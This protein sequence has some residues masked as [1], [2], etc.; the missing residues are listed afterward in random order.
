M[1]A[2]KSTAR[3]LLILLLMLTSVSLIQ[4]QDDEPVIGPPVV[5]YISSPSRSFTVTDQSL[6]VIGTVIV[7]PEVVAY[8]KV[9]I[10]GTAR[11]SF[12]ARD[13]MDRTLAFD[14]LTIGDI[15][16]DT[17]VEGELARLPHWPGISTGNWLL[18]LV[19]VG[20]DS[21][22]VVPEF[23]V[24]FRVQVP[25]TD[26]VY[27]NIT[28]PAP[29]QIL[30][31]GSEILGTILMDQWVTEYRLELIGGD[32]TSWT[33]VHSELSN[34]GNPTR[35]TDGVLGHLPALDTLAPGQYRLRVV[36]IGWNGQ[37]RQEPREIDFAVGTNR[38]TNLSSIRLTQPRVSGDR[39][40]ITT[41]TPLIGTVIVPEG[42][43]YYKVEIKDDIRSGSEQAVRFYEWT[44]I[45]STHSE[46]VIDG[47]IEY[48]AGVPD[49]APG[50]YRL[51]IVVIGADGTFSGTPLEV[52]LT[53]REP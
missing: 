38:V 26:P 19:V 33:L 46:S 3:L 8:W 16:T 1:Q 20:H 35:I 2:T 52:S 34:T 42:A 48:L 14:W 5:A 17:V 32:F 7:D 4:A 18:R 28:R 10:R 41:G 50:T 37:F 25:E 11:N 45:G 36:V 40:T 15:R 22:F 13:L 49:I 27:I 21:T 9:E 39:I 6:P 43:Q 31:G 29:G 53:V 23:V 24:P 44:T 47:Q 51:R 12:L 30:T